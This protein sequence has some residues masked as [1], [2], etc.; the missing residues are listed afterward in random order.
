LSICL[1]FSDSSLMGFYL[2][3]LS[4]FVA[5]MLFAA[6]AAQG[7]GR[8]VWAG[9]CLSLATVK[10][11]TMLP[12]LLLFL[13]KADRWTW[14]TL[15]VLVLGFCSLTGRTHEL[16]GRIATIADRIGEFSSPGRVNDY[17]FEG[18]R[19]E[20][21]IGLE[22][23]FYRLGLRG[24][25][26]IRNAQYIGLLMIGAGVAYSV[27]WGGTSRPAACALVALYSILFL[28]HRDYDSVILA[29]PLVYGACRVRAAPGRG[30]RPSVAI[31]LL[32]IAVL[33]LNAFLLRPLAK[34]SLES[35]GWG[36]LVQATVLPYATW[37]ILAAMLILS[38]GAM[39]GRRISRP[40]R[41][42][43]GG[44]NPD[45][46]SPWRAEAAILPDIL[47]RSGVDWNRGPESA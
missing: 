23:L 22:P 10:V 28:Y 39:R 42:E 5:V 27:L 14:V 41:R 20:S 19:N 16:P 13:R 3:Q 21:I 6:L 33:Y 17:S 47:A 26:S 24:R 15:I 18:P 36:R 4:V 44:R 29:M 32:V 2:G 38:L 7:T 34:W 37:M 9:V 25:A 12:F 31:G 43:G 40:D 35:G 45:P 1:T 46:G 30:H 8:P 11:G